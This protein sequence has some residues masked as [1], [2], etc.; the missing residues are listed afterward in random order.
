MSLKKA[1]AERVRTKRQIP[2]EQWD[3]LQGEYKESLRLCFL[4]TTDDRDTGYWYGFESE[5]QKATPVFKAKTES[6]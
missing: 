6:K 2:P 1:P 4:P 3:V 5:S